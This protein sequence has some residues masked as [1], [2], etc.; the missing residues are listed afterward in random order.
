MESADVEQ[1]GQ[2]ALDIA[3]ALERVEG[4]RA[5]LEELL[6]LFVDECRSS[7]SHIQE[8]WR[9]RDTLMLGRLAHTLKGSSANVAANAVSRAAY[10]LERQARSGNLENAPQLISDLKREVERVIPELDSVLRQAAR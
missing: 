7:M 5:L 1:T 3:A 6:R 2:P 4:D 9:S 8:A 10:A